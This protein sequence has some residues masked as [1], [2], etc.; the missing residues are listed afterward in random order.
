MR[1]YGFL[2]EWRSAYSTFLPLEICFRVDSSAGDVLHEI[3]MA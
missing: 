1:N 3:G 2:E